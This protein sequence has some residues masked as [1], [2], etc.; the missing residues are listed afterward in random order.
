MNC[1]EFAGHICRGRERFRLKP[2]FQN[3]AV[4]LNRRRGEKHPRKA[5]KHGGQLLFLLV[6]HMLDRTTWR[7]MSFNVLLH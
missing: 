4:C 5:K 2:R 7:S 3:G 1:D 6:V